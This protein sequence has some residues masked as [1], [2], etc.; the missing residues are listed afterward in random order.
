MTG[1]VVARLHQELEE[2]HLAVS[3][4]DLALHLVEMKCADGEK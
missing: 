4:I 1:T 3:K 2:H